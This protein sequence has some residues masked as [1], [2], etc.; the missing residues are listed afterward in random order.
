[1]KIGHFLECKELYLKFKMFLNLKIEK[2]RIFF[3]PERVN[4]PTFSSAGCNNYLEYSGR[5]I[6]GLSGSQLKQLY[7]M[8]W[9]SKFVKFFFACLISVGLI[10]DS[11]SPGWTI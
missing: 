6:H 2:I 7:Q 1:M 5:T 3:L 10:I 9:K 11:P 4:W 8:T